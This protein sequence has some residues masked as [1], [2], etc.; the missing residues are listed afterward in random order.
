[1]NRVHLLPQYATGDAKG[2]TRTNI[3]ALFVMGKG[4]VPI[5]L[6]TIGAEGIE[7]TVENALVRVMHPHLIGVEAAIR[8]M[9]SSARVGR[10]VWQRRV[11]E[12]RAGWQLVAAIV[13]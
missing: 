1:V 7:Q 3:D 11:S 4:I 8:I 12:R 6:F 9:I 5:H 13:E 10:V 2:I